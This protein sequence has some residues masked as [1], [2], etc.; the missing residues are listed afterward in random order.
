MTCDN[1]DLLSSMEVSSFLTDHAAIHC[2]LKVT[3]PPPGKKL[4]TY[5]YFK[6]I[7]HK[8]VAVD[9][10]S[11]QLLVNPEDDLNKLINQYETELSSILDRHVRLKEKRITLHLPYPYGT[12]WRLRR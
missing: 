3:K 8:K 1:E 2:S 7:D 10:C 12:H 4:I 5:R 11:S 6:S 9:F